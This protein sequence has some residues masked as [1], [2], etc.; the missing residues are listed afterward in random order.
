[1]MRPVSDLSGLVPPLGLSLIHFLW[2]G[3]AIAVALRL[4]L[5]LCRSPRA[6]YGWSLAAMAAMAAAPAATFWMLASRSPEPGISAVAPVA[7]PASGPAWTWLAVAGWA[8]GASMLGLRAIVGFALVE[9]LRRRSRP[10]PTAWAERCRALACQ[11]AAPLRVAFAQSQ[12]IAGPIVAG[13]FR[14]I[15]LIPTAALTRMPVEQLEALILHELAHVRRFDAVANLFQ[16]VVEILLFYHPATWWVSRTIRIEREHCCDDMAVTEIGDAALYVRALQ[17]LAQLPPLPSAALA[18]TGAPLVERVRRLLVAEAPV[19]KFDLRALAA[20]FVALAV[21]TFGWSAHVEAK[22]QRK[23]AAVAQIA[24]QE[25]DSEGATRSDEA[26]VD[27]SSDAADDM[28]RIPHRSRTDMVDRVREAARSDAGNFEHS[29]DAAL[30]NYQAALRRYYAELARYHATPDLQR[31]D[32]NRQLGEASLALGAA[33]RR[34]SRRSASSEP[35]SASPH[36]R[37]TM[38]A[39]ISSEQG[40]TTVDTSGPTLSIS[41]SASNVLFLL[42][43]QRSSRAALTAVPPGQVARLEA[44]TAGS[45]PA[46]SLGARPDQSVVNVVTK[47][48]T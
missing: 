24:K 8:A 25:Q 1:M 2:Q 43:G 35:G 7:A 34:L 4:V 22:A 42:D 14:P 5:A 37:K 36:I 13:L 46:R 26:G 12:N 11:A 32:A 33:S 44:I 47:P 18:A 30:S 31:A 27:R 16:T 17:T 48:P 9:R 19:R 45:A 40:T 6:R 3:A 23:P 21:L 39:T 41:G 29:Y 38:T 20:S 28:A 10:L 15:V